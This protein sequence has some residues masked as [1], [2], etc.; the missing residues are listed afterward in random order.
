[1]KNKNEDSTD[2]YSFIQI[3]KR[4]QVWKK[5][6]SLKDLKLSVYVG[7]EPS[8]FVTTSPTGGRL[9]GLHGDGKARPDGPKVLYG[10]S[11]SRSHQQIWKQPSGQL[12]VPS[13]HQPHPSK[14][15]QEASDYTAHCYIKKVV[16]A[17]I[18]SSHSAQACSARRR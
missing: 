9:L 2:A 13:D 4:R 17:S 8:T 15:R 14:H 12:D 16:M 10:R 18:E 6:V 3:Y 7:T 11:R 5:Q 1:M